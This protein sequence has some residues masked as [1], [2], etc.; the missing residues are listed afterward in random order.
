MILDDRYDT[1]Q[2]PEGC[3]KEVLSIETSKKSACCP[4]FAQLHQLFKIF[5]RLNCNTRVMVNASS[6]PQVSHVKLL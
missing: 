4:F 2:P 3:A 5:S 1:G 6:N